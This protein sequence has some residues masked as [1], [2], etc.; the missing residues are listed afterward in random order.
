[1]TPRGAAPLIAMRMAGQRPAVDVWV[2]VGDFSEPDWW[3]W[4]ETAG[5]PEILV[6]PE[7]PIERLDLRCLVGLRLVLFFSAWD[8]RVARLYDRLQDYADEITVMSPAFDTDIGWYWLKGRGRIE[9]EERHWLTQFD[10]ARVNATAA[11]V[12]G[13]KAAYQAA[14]AAELEAIRRAPWLR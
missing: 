14:Q 11:A 12:K 4:A 3:R 6:H 13:D 9:I 10:E 1:M 8:D 7:D 2:S 5:Q